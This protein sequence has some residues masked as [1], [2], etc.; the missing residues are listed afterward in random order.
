MTGLGEKGLGEY[1]AY[2]A[3]KEKSIATID[4]YLRDV[5]TFL[6]W[7]GE[8]QDITKEKV[9]AIRHGY[10]NTIRPAA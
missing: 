4:K 3:Q 6:Q 2:L 8:G 10:R 9:I 1:R 7:L 5:R